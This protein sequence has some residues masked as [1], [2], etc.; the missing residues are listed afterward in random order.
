MSIPDFVDRQ[1]HMIIHSTRSGYR[2]WNNPYQ[3]PE[4]N[5]QG[6]D[7]EEPSPGSVNEEDDNDDEDGSLGKRRPHVNDPSATTQ[8]ALGPTEEDDGRDI[9]ILDLHSNQPIVSYRGRVFTGEW[10]ANI[11]TELLF[12]S[13]DEK[14]P[15]EAL[16]KLSD[17]T[18]L[19]GM[20]AAR[21]SCT[22]AELWPR[23]E[24]TDDRLQAARAQNGFAIPIHSDVSGARQPQAA[25][26][27]RLMAIK[28]VRGETDLVTVKAVDSRHDMVLDDPIE[29]ARRRKRKK[30]QARS[31]ER[32]A[33]LHPPTGEK[34]RRMR[35]KTR[36]LLGSPEGSRNQEVESV[37]TPP[38]LAGMV[39]V[40]RGG[41]GG[42]SSEVKD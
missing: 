10:S 30:D 7:G 25:F 14:E 33:L 5:K 26:L 32:W 39:D 38:T 2:N 41:D 40:A 29:E 6:V 20:S 8:E 17:K 16:R 27:E 31:K 22:P 24:L 23:P 19:V 35:G 15:L 18:D 12:T 3:D 4:G 34:K 36:W 11:G 9:Q 42:G 13:H 1:D 37:P 28:S 21:I